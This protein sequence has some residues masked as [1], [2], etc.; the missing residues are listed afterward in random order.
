[1]IKTSKGKSIK[2]AQ[3][4]KIIAERKATVERLRED[5]NSVGAC[6]ESE[7]L[8]FTLGYIRALEELL[9]KSNSTNWDFM[10][11]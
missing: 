5:A 1:M 11:K 6:W 10:G 8:G 2:P 4:E 7:K 3:I 9:G